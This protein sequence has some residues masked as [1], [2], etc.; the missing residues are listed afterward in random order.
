MLH[1]TVQFVNGELSEWQEPES[2]LSD[3]KELERGG[4]Q[5]RALVDALISDDW[6][7][8][9]RSVS[10]KGTLEDGT[11]VNRSIPYR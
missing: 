5:G 6:G 1:L 9:P 10:I 8:P 2:I 7:V 11:H 4:L 3:L